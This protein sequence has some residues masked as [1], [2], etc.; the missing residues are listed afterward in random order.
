MLHPNQAEF[1]PPQ[2]HQ[3][4]ELNFSECCQSW[5]F[6]TILG[7]R[8]LGFLIFAVN[9][10]SSDPKATEWFTNDAMTVVAQRR[11]GMINLIIS[12]DKI[13][14]TSR[15]KRDTGEQDMRRHLLSR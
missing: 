8:A 6:K 2:N 5:S 13:G 10:G 11:R 15:E 14:A 9:L 3:G 4:L 1:L 12:L 7:V